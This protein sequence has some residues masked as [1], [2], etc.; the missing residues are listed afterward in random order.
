MFKLNPINL[1]IIIIF[2]FFINYQIIEK[3]TDLT[4]LSQDNLNKIRKV[5]LFVKNNISDGNTITLNNSLTVDELMINQDKQNQ[6][7]QISIGSDSSK[8]IILSRGEADKNNYVSDNLQF[9]Y[10]GNGRKWDTG[11]IFDKNGGFRIQANGGSKYGINQNLKVKNLNVNGNLLINGT[12]ISS[13]ANNTFIEHNNKKTNAI[14][15]DIDKINGKSINEDYLHRPIS[16]NPNSNS[17]FKIQYSKDNLTVYV[18]K[19]FTRKGNI[20]DA[21]KDFMLV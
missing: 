14:L 7:Y 12:K 13:N 3:N 5:S 16:E 6:L 20:D 21:I 2:Y 10:N 19:D 8:W 1:I 15:A 17:L 4:E 9:I 11:M 18:D